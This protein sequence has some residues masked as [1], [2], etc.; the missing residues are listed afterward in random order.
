MKKII[1]DLKTLIKIICFSFK[2]CYDASKFYL[3]VNLLINC[4]LI[5]IPFA[6]IYIGSKTLGYIADSLIENADIN[7]KIGGFIVLI[8][9]TF[10]INVI[11]NL[12]QSLT[13]YIKKM[14]TEQINSKLKVDI[15]KKASYLEMKYFDS[16]DFFDTLND[17]NYS[18][19]MISNLVFV[20]FDFVYSL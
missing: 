20:V 17:V 11:S 18:S 19:S 8:A 3:I 2:L 6:S 13:F 12:M 5:V 7:D 15:M 16:P 4:V 10:L 1:E 9:L 14:Y